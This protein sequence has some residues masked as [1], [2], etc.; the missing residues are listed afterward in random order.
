MRSAVQQ[1][2]A[3]SAAELPMR[4]IDS[5]SERLILSNMLARGAFCRTVLP[6]LSAEDFVIDQHRRVFQLL[7]DA[8]RHGHEPGLS[9]AYRR[10]LDL[11]KTT[12]E[13]GLPLLSGLAWNNTIDLP[14]AAPWVN[15]IRRKRAERKAW[16]L[17][18]RMR[19]E[20]ESGADACEAI[21]TG[22][23][24]LRKLQADLEPSPPSSGTIAGAISEIGV[25]ALLSTPRGVIA[26]PWPKLTD[27]VNGGPRP[28]ELWIVASRPSIG[29]TTAA[30]QWALF[31]AAEG[32]PSQFYSLE[33]PRA[34]LLKR[35]LSAEGNIAHG[36]LVR[37]DLSPEWRFRVAQT[38]D[39]I[40]GYPLDIDDKCR[41]LKSIIAKIAASA[42]K[43]LDLVV[44]DYLGLVEMDGR[45]ENRN[46]EVSALSRRLK[47]A[48]MDYGVPI[49]CAHQLSRANETERRRPQLSDLRDSG[50]LEQ[51]ADVVL[52]L[53]APSSRKRDEF[54]K[55]SVEV[56]IAKQR[57]GPRG[58]VVNLKIESRFC[59]LAEVQD[60]GGGEGA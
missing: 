54:P 55:D 60:T 6:Q 11:G 41:T 56:L 34:D 53:D 31:A 44:I 32:H 35:M 26:S 29:K 46:A 1:D 19:V 58:Y 22:G 50:S 8:S 9:G 25:D 12:E 57:N 21:T 24:Q 7:E 37:G 18:E 5:E 3:P 47:M 14:D 38:V 48:A 42:N 10:L 49:I 2:S 20:I 30:L 13:L 15:R 59:R 28:G 36:L 51:D 45:F 52:M 40:G 23:E 17:A 27:L 4:L 33:M 39:R 16:Q 43:G